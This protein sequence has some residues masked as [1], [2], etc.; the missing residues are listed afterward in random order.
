MMFHFHGCHPRRMHRQGARWAAFAQAMAEEAQKRGYGE[1]GGRGGFGRRRMFDGDTLRLVLLKLIWEEPRHGYDLIRAIGEASGGVYA[2]SPGM[3][4]PLLTLLA[5]QGL[6]SETADGSRRRF[7][8]T[9]AGSAE[10]AQ[11][12]EAV[13]AAFK[14][15]ADLAAAARPDEAAPVR[16]A[17]DNLKA[18][19]QARMAAQGADKD[20]GFAIAAL[21]DEVAQK[22]ER[23]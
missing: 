1:R 2:P 10:L 5:D 6:I 19:A 14:Q 15:L 11:E 3:V 21:L 18:A 20:T 12:A 17:F 23:M 8:I 22:I 4:Y 16:R 7:A 9:E 13:E